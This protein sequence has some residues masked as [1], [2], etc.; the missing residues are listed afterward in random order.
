MARLR[1]PPPGITSMAVPVAFSLGGKYGVSEGLWMLQTDISPLG[2]FA[3]TS[4]AVFA[5]EPG[6]PSG[7]SGI[8][9]GISAAKIGSSA[10]NQTSSSVFIVMERTDNSRMQS[11]DHPGTR[12]AH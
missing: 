8:S 4:L 5:S 7:H 10:S 11:S 12:K 9:F 3:T 2:D 1:W 6:A